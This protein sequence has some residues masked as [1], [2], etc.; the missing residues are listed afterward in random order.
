MTTSGAAVATVGQREA[1]NIAEGG[2][3]TGGSEG[4]GVVVLQVQVFVLSSAELLP[5]CVH[6]GHSFLFFSL[7]THEMLVGSDGVG[8][9]CHKRDI[10][11]MEIIHRVPKSNIPVP[12]P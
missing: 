4:H 7:R 10:H 1:A 12:A 2:V 3:Q 6:Y 8:R 9:A 11:N 5:T